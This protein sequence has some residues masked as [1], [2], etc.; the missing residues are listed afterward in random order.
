MHPMLLLF[1]YVLLALAV[2]FLCSI[3]EA[4]LLSVAPGYVSALEQEKPAAAARLRA[5]K[6]NVDRPLAAILSLN[7]IAH[8]LGAAGAGAQ[9]QRVF[10]EAW[11]TAFS[12]LL[13]LLILVASEIVPKTIGALYWRPL[14]PA[15]ARILG[16]LIWLVYPLVRLSELIT[17]LLARGREP[18]PMSR[19][20]LEAMATLGKEQGLIDEIESQT[21]EHLLRFGSLRARDAMTPRPVMLTLPAHLTVGEALAR[22]PD[23][24]FS[25]IPLTGERPDDILGY[26]LKDDILMAAAR[27]E[28]DRPL[29]DFRRDVTLVPE[30]MPLW[31]LLKQLLASGEHIAITVD[32]YGGIVGVV[33]LE[34]LVETLLGLEIVDEVDRVEDLQRLARERWRERAKQLGLVIDEEEPPPPADR[35]REGGEEGRSA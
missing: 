27:D 30:L 33:T 21:L 15:V 18:E 3:M 2:S 24:H 17:A 19:S 14:A 23:L 31:V 7:T 28:H 4:V 1:S 32:E 22:H 34:D 35:A 26:V 29:T 8:T 5:L 6:E 25:R 12:I 20:E 11:V 16:P 10:G 13:T 9:A